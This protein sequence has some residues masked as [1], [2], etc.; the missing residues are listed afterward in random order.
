VG[1][2]QR[3]GGT[4]WGGAKHGWGTVRVT[5]DVGKVGMEQGRGAFRCKCGKMRRDR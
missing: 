1:V 3:K 4:K 5:Q 2:G